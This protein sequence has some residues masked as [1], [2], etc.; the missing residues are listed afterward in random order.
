MKELEPFGLSTAAFRSGISCVRARRLLKS[1]SA[2]GL[3]DSF[4]HASCLSCVTFI[5][6]RSD[7]GRDWR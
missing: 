2:L 1:G 7:V 3:S 5:G 4:F 6:F